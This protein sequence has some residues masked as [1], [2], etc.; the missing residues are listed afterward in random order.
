VLSLIEGRLN[1]TLK[2]KLQESAGLPSRRRRKGRSNAGLGRKKSKAVDG[3]I[4]A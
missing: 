1:R 3:E 2:D 4:A